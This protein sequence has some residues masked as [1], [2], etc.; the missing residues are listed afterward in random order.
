MVIK[1]TRHLTD[2]DPQPT[3]TYCLQQK[4]LQELVNVTRRHLTIIK[5]RMVEE[6]R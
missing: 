2:F 1:E 5:I 4:S 3:A 6:W